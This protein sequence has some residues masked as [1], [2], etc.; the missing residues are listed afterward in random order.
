MQFDSVFLFT[1]FQLSLK[2]LA[3][4]PDAI[5]RQLPSN[6]QAQMSVMASIRTVGIPLLSQLVETDPPSD[7]WEVVARKAFSWCKGNN[8]SFNIC[9]ECDRVQFGYHIGDFYIRRDFNVDTP[10]VKLE[11]LFQLHTTMRRL[12]YRLA[13]WFPHGYPTTDGSAYPY[14]SFN[15]GGK[16]YHMSGILYIKVEHEQLVINGDICATP[17]ECDRALDGILAH[18]K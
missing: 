7:I 12:Q 16:V 3:A 1:Y 8:D 15:R 14:V 11:T 2:C 17:E 6:D 10:G 9:I 5:F 18:R 13:D 4:V